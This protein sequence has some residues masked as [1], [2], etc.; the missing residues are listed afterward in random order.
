MAKVR[1]GGEQAP[2]FALR[3][4]GG[5][6]RLLKPEIA[7][8]GVAGG[9]RAERPAVFALAVCDRK[10]VDAGDALAHQALFV[11]FPILV[12]IAAEPMAAVIM[13]LISKADG[14]AV[15]AESPDFLDRGSRARESIC[16]LE[17]PQWP[18]GLAGTRRDCASGYRPYR[19]KCHAAR[20]AGVPGVLGH[21]GLLGDGLSRER[22]QRGAR[23]GDLGYRCGRSVSRPSGES[24]ARCLSTDR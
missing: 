17:T 5:D 12:A 23:H 2:R 11:E 7:Q 13:P 21:A 6:D 14:D 18:R 8:G 24:M 16:A 9:A 15:V 3:R 20:I 22:R 19:G 10:I 1:A 4:L